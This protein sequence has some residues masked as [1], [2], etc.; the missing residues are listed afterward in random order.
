MTRQPL[1]GAVAI[2]S[3]LAAFFAVFLASLAITGITGTISSISEATGQDIPFILG[4][5]L[6]TLAAFGGMP[7]AHLSL[8]IGSVG[9]TFALIPFILTALAA[10][11]IYKLHN[12]SESRNTLGDA[13]DQVMNALI[14]GMVLL[15][16]CVASWFIADLLNPDTSQAS[17]TS[18]VFLVAAGS[19]FIGVGWAMAGRQTLHGS[20]R[21]RSVLPAFGFALRYVVIAG[22]P[23]A[24][25]ACFILTVFYDWGAS[26]WLLLGNFVAAGWNGIHGGFVTWS[27]DLRPLGLPSEDRTVWAPLI[28]HADWWTG[29]A[30]FI[31]I[32]AFSAGT[33]WWSR[34]CRSCPR[35]A[36]P[37]AFATVS[38]VSLAVGAFA[39]GYVT[40]GADR[41]SVT[42]LV[43]LS[44]ITILITA[45]VGCCMDT[46][47]RLLMSAN[48][49]DNPSTGSYPLHQGDTGFF[50]SR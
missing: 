48:R 7:E 26:T 47:A 15:M 23:P 10:L 19:L 36:L 1:D 33:Y 14:T 46:L 24:L 21:R 32:V 16:C 42:A 41:G 40:L 28:P 4:A 17:L 12:Y 22:L 6:L 35:W 30:V 45:F 18:N 34:S 9:L 11:I 27:L 37:V 3:P 20:Y 5:L 29:V 43:S 50:A 25:L 44:P 13:A 8:T 31:G 2:G 49:T 39:T 38:I